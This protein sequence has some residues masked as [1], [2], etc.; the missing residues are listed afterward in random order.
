MR[1]PQSLSVSFRL[2]VALWLNLRLGVEFI[3]YATGQPVPKV[4]WH[5][6][7]IELSKSDLI[8]LM[9]LCVEVGGRFARADW[10]MLNEWLAQM[11]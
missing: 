11:P 10:S 9:K 7:V 3:L 5:W 1:L 2:T 4:P 6:L 8:W